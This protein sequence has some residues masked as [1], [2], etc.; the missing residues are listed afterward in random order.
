MIKQRICNS[1]MADTSDTFYGVYSQIN[2]YSCGFY[3]GYLNS[4]KYEN[5]KENSIVCMVTYL[6][7]KEMHRTKYVILVKTKLSAKSEY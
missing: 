3:G 2:Q 7:Y 1:F 6:N 4:I 5:S